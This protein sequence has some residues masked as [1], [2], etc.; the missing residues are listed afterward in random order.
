[1]GKKN[2]GG[3]D[4]ISKIPKGIWLFISYRCHACMDAVICDAADSKMFSKCGESSGVHRINAGRKRNFAAGYRKQFDFRI[5]G[6]PSGI[7]DFCA[8][9]LSDGL[10]QTGTV[11]S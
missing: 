6:I 8:G 5:L 1:M 11:Y 10:V 3:A 2:K 7:C 9:S 4:F